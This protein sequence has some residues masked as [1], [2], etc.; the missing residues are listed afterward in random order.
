M[1]TRIVTT[2]GDADLAGVTI[3]RTRAEAVPRAT[4]TAENP[5]TN[6]EVPSTIRPRRAD[7]RS[8]PDSPVA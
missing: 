2:P 1:P 6:S 8:A 4:K 7:S 3:S 5:S